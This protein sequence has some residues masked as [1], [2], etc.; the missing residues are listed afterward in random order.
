MNVFSFTVFY[1]I[2]WDFDLASLK[3]LIYHMQLPKLSFVESF[4]AILF[5]LCLWNKFSLI[6]DSQVAESQY[7]KLRELMNKSYIVPWKLHHH[8][9]L[10]QRRHFGILNPEGLIIVCKFASLN[11]QIWGVK[12]P[13]APLLMGSL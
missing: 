13:S 4:D 2:F 11:N 9:L 8:G 12:T 3:L 6:W 10:V 7:F 1:V 5:F